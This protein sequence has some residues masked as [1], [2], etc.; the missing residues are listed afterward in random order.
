MRL[1]F[2]AKN[3]YA[4]WLM[5]AVALY[6]GAALISASFHTPLLFDAASNAII[7]KNL[8]L[9]YGWATSYHTRSLTPS[10][11]S[12]PTIMVPCAILIAL[13]G[14]HLW[15]PA[16][17]MA[18]IN[19]ALVCILCYR[20]QR[21]HRNS[22]HALGI[23]L[24]FLGALMLYDNL[25]LT[26]LVGEIPG[27][28]LL[29]IAATF[30]ADKRIL[31]DR[32]LLFC[33]GIC[34]SL[35]MLCRLIVLPGIAALSGL[36]AL[37]YI[38]AF[39][40]KAKT[41]PA[42]SRD[43]FILICGC[44]LVAGPYMA[45]IGW[46]ILTSNTQ[47]LQDYLAFRKNLF[48][49]NKAVGIGKLLASNDV[50]GTLRINTIQN[51]ALLEQA[52]KTHGLWPMV[53][54]VS[55]LALLARCAIKRSCQPLLDNTFLHAL[56]LMLIAY[57]A[58]YIPIP[59]TW[60]QTRYT[61]YPALLGCLTLTVLLVRYIH[62]AGGM[63][64]IMAACYLAAPSPQQLFTQL[65]Q[66]QKVQWL[67]HQSNH[68]YPELYNYHHDIRSVYAFLE[69]GSFRYP[70]A[71]CGWI[72]ATP[73]VELLFPY[74]EVFLDCYLMINEAMEPIPGTE[75]KPQEPQYRW[76]HPVSFTLLINK[77]TWQY[78]ESSRLEKAR[79]AIINHACD[80]KPLYEN[81]WYKV[82]ECPFE[83]ISTHVPLTRNNPFI[84]TRPGWMLDP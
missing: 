24:G 14:Q 66:F 83:A 30:V 2:T 73:E 84:E 42:I 17:T 26:M 49:Y 13:F 31:D 23:M 60:G 5:I 76:R 80:G 41:L 82:V 63:L 34:F 55:T 25:W 64:A 72:T 50:P 61:L 32:K 1:T 35:A 44:L 46:E 10:L 7:P 48:R 20:M 71:N 38:H 19:T 51:L 37:R 21:L 18:I 28:L 43:V 75:G 56:M 62:P 40:L 22:W 52:L 78:S 57:L 74:P 36:L 27:L 54:M 77:A 81:P 9:G 69:N 33:L 59:A 39:R 53:F 65:S 15:I 58:W 3:I 6:F 47:S 8:N 16:L 29:V 11:S 4:C 68:Q 79:H 67:E 45:Y 70:L 12:G